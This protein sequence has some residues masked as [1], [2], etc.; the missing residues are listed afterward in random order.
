MKEL[1]AVDQL[2][3]VPGGKGGGKILKSPDHLQHGKGSPLH[4]KTEAHT[5]LIK[6]L[7]TAKHITVPV[8][9]AFQHS[10]NVILG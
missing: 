10:S 6:T 5:G 7:S 1:K 9:L 8:V 2:H 4:T 3:K